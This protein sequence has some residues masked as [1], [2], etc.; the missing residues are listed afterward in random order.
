MSADKG[1]E[2]METIVN[3]VLLGAGAICINAVI[4]LA[5]FEMWRDE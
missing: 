2:M 3:V 5:L 1:K 4:M